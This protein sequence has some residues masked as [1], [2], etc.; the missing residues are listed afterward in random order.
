M[1]LF[2]S[3]HTESGRPSVSSTIDSEGFSR[4]N[5]QTSYSVIRPWPKSVLDEKSGWD[6]LTGGIVTGLGIFFGGAEENIRNPSKNF[7]RN[8]R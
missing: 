1:E 3:S 2:S 4:K 5:S 6:D 7:L 8:I